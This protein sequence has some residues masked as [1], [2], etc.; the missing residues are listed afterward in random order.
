MFKVFRPQGV[1]PVAADAWDYVQIA[2]PDLHA[3][4]SLTSDSDVQPF[5][6]LRAAGEVD[7]TR[8]R[9]AVT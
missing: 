6:G 8:W 3:S 2:G 9:E 1:K 7:T 5:L 4:R